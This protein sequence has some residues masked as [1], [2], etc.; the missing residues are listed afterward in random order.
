[1][2]WKLGGLQPFYPFGTDG[3]KYLST[4]V[5][6]SGRLRR[7]ADMPTLRIFNSLAPIL[8][9]SWEA[10]WRVRSRNTRGPSSAG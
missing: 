3:A 4:K 8:A 6:A 5:R 9:A 10:G 7:A 2:F 1:M